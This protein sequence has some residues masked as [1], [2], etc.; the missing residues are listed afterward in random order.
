M[1]EFDSPDS[2]FTRNILFTLFLSLPLRY[3]CNEESPSGQKHAQSHSLFVVRKAEIWV[4]V[5]FVFFVTEIRVLVFFVFFFVTGDG[6]NSH[7]FIWRLC[8]TQEKTKLII[9]E[10]WAKKTFYWSINLVSTMSHVTKQVT[11]SRNRKQWGRGCFKWRL[12]VFHTSREFNDL[13]F[14]QN[15]S[16]KKTEN[17]GDEVATNGE[18]PLVMHIF[19]IKQ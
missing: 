12:Q 7:Y 18:Y 19:L 13:N 15:S 1:N 5:F 16:E 2:F 10:R 14:V 17:T 11:P 4:P 8:V 9:F 3:F 6:F